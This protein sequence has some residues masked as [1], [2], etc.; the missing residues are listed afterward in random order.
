MGNVGSGIA[1]RRLI[2]L[3][4]Y[5][6]LLPINIP[7]AAHLSSEMHTVPAQPRVRGALGFCGGPGQ[8]PVPGICGQ[9]LAATLDLSLSVYGRLGACPK[10]NQP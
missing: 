2:A 5:P 10:G 9:A 6:A 8:P 4:A 3:D 7:A 1:S